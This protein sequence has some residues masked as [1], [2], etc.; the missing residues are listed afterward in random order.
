MF[1]EPLTHLLIGPS[2]LKGVGV[3]VVVLGPGSQHM[4]LELFLALPGCPFQVIMLERMD[5]DFCLVKP[6]GVGW[7]IPRLPPAATFGEIA[8]RAGGYVARPAV[9]NQEDSA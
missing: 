5:E 8:S 4:G 1:C 6:R 2:P 7:R 3:A 9:L